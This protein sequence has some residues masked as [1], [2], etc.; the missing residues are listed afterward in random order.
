MRWGSILNSGTNSIGANPIGANIHVTLQ[1]QT[2]TDLLGEG[3]AE[4]VVTESAT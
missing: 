3:G 1:I 2:E 4:V